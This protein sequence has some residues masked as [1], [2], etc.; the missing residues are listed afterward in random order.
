MQFL[1]FQPPFH[2]K[3]LDLYGNPIDE[4]TDWNWIITSNLVSLRITLSSVVTDEIIT[5]EQL[6]MLTLHS[7]NGSSLDENTEQILKTMTKLENLTLG[8]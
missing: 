8:K 3:K 6:S 4:I 7:N 2:G 1:F 5:F